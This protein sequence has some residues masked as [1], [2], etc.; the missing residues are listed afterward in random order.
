MGVMLE[1]G[2]RGLVGLAVDDGL[3]GSMPSAVPWGS[4][5]G[6]EYLPTRPACIL[7][8]VGL[9]LIALLLGVGSLGKEGWGVRRVP[10]A[11]WGHR[12]ITALKAGEEQLP[13][14]APGGLEFKCS[15][16]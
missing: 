4:L 2:L 14:E 10:R 15:R 13:P 7:L 8:S 9:C 16:V 1:P 11:C 6:V 3:W 5:N 12:G